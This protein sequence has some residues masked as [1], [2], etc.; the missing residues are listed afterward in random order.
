MKKFFFFPLWKIENLEGKLS[1]LEQNGWRLDRLSPFNCFHFVEATAKDTSYFFTYKLIKENGMAD[2]EHFLKSK[3]NA[4]P[5]RGTPAASTSSDV[6]EYY[7]QC[8]LKIGAGSGNRTRIASLEGW[9]STIELH[10]HIYI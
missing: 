1:K 6:G 8:G 7:K 3:H 9:N 2:I 5:V 10:L 4:N